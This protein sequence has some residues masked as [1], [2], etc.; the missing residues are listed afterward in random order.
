MIIL[1]IDQKDVCYA[2]SA[3]KF[4]VLYFDG[5]LH[6]TVILYGQISLCKASRLTL[7]S[8]GY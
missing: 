7:K 5:H 4:T 6:V 1:I 2:G 8:S 3:N